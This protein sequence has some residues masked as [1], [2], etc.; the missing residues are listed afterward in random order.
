METP[1]NLEAERLLRNNTPIDDFLGM[2]PSEVHVLLYD[3]FG[4][5]SPIQF[6]PGIDDGILD[7]IPLFRIAEA[8]L[9]IVQRDKQIKLTPLGA[10][11]KKVMVEIYAHRFLPD[12][13]IEH[14]IVKLTRE[15]DC[16]SI[17]NAR[18]ALELAGLAKKVHGKITLTKA[19]EKLLQTNN[20]VQIFK[21]FFQAF[22]DKFD[23]GFNDAYPEEP[24]GQFGWAFT[25]I[26]LDKFGDQPRTAD[27]YAERYLRAFPNLLSFSRPSYT[28]TTEGVFTRCYALRTFSRFLVWFGFAIVDKKGRITDLSR[29]QITGTDLVKKVFKIDAG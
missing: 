1:D 26:L 7:Q 14:G 8:Y 3:T 2:T 23:W 9:K 27:F 29:G 22:T 25:M 16:I 5:K 18:L 4:N 6:N 24:I 13:A 21:K 19:G 20:R 28:L 15:H 17:Q 12:E 11:P 10:L